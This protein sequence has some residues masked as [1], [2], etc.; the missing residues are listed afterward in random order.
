MPIIVKDFTWTQTAT[1]INIRVPMS[2]VNHER[3]DLFTTDSYVKA[4]Y[5][6]FFFEV[7]LLH[8]VENKKSKCTVKD[9]LI[10]FDLVKK[11]EIDWECLEKELSKD[12]KLKRKEEIYQKSQEE[13]KKESDDR[14]VRKSQMD[15]FTVQQ[16]MQIDNQQHILMDSRR[17]EQRKKAMDALEEWRVQTKDGVEPRRKKESGVKIIELPSSEDEKHETTVPKPD[18]QIKRAVPKKSLQIPVKSEYIDKKKEESSKR[19]LP[20][21]RESAELQIKH[22]PRTFPTPSRE[23]TADEEQAW[24]KNVT[25]ARRATGT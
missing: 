16:A 14:N 6:P 1:T 15:R 9:D 5:S 7:F 3:V 17:D 10:T 12:E 19:V 13:A 2:L 23:S 24:L 21:L 4:H 8:D 25:L 20:K 18:L 11:E 22:T